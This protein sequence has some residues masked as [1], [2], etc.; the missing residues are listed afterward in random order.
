MLFDFLTATWVHIFMVQKTCQTKLEAG[1]SCSLES[2]PSWEIK[3]AQIKSQ[4]MQNKSALS[5]Y[6][7]FINPLLSTPQVLVLSKKTYKHIINITWY[8]VPIPNR[9]KRRS[10]SSKQLKDSRFAPCHGIGLDEDLVKATNQWWFMEIP[11][12]PFRFH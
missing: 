8:P 1:M 12:F 5:L 2:K 3:P 9:K 10:A 7:T 4:I 6:Q 11:R